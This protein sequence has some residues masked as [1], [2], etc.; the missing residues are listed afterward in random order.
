MFRVVRR[1]ILGAVLAAGLAVPA[2]AHASASED[3]MVAE[4]NEAR[5]EQGLAALRTSPLLSDSAASYSRYMLA[6]DYF[7]HLPEVRASNK[8]TL[9]GE[10]LAWHTGSAPRVGQT[11]RSWLRSSSHRAVLLHPKVR[12]VGAGVER[13]QFGGQYSTVWTVQVGRM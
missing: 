8:F 4:I 3:S 5:R 9:K 7:G 12:W 1:L 6:R 2:H 10:V 11:V 13:G